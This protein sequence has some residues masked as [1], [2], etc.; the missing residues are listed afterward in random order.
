MEEKKHKNI[1]LRSEEVQEIMNDIP[2]WILRWGIV[3]LFIIV[4]VIATGTWFIKYPDVIQTEVVINS[5]EPPIS[6][7]ARAS[8]KIDSIYVT[9][10]E[11]VMPEQLLAVIQNTAS[12]A[13]ICYLQS[14]INK[15][16]QSGM[17]IVGVHTL[18]RPDF[19]LGTV[20]PVYASFLTRLTNYLSDKEVDY[21]KRKLN[22]QQ[23]ALA[24]K[25]NYLEHLQQQHVLVEE[26][27]R[28]SKNIFDRDSILFVQEII[29]GNDY[30]VSRNNYLQHKQNILSSQGTMKLHAMQVNSQKEAL[31]DLR[32]K[33][34]ETET[35]RKMELDNGFQALKTAM[36]SWE[37]NYLIR[38]PI[39]GTVNFMGIWSKNRHV[40]VGEEVFVIIPN[41]QDIPTAKAKLP[42]QGAGKVKEGQIV[43]VR[44]T[45][46]PD[47][48]FGYLKG[49]VASISNTPTKDGFYI[50]DIR[51]PKGIV[52]N[53]DIIL[54]M[55]QQMHGVA[56]IIT[57]D[58]TLLERIA[59]PMKNLLKD[60][61]SSSY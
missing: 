36:Q 12:I 32:Q 8:G 4:V 58:L 38:T 50:V 56:D 35:M 59:M 13:D 53:Y 49:I 1:E 29:T 39:S 43:N 40:T 17:N 55:S 31:F 48:E 44:V 10:G 15:W 20:Q 26:Q 45:N 11:A 37:E 16:E 2:L 60:R 18:F 52:T 54:P 5:L 51:F 19:A 28:L 7:V 61:A 9:N 33:I 30:D 21:Y 47:Q 14:A 22:Y 23:Q 24:D 42:V 46:F 25:E 6:T 34:I 57:N 41:N 3:T 27:F